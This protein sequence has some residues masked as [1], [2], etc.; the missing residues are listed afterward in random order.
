MEGTN[1]RLDASYLFMSVVIY[2]FV[3]K[4]GGQFQGAR[5]SL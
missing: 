3:L 5:G 1:D 4:H 2:W